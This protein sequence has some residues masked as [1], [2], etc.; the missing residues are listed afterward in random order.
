MSFSFRKRRGNL[1]L[2]STIEITL[3]VSPGVRHRSED[4]ADVKEH[5]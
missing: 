3:P 5:P 1:S 4:T 2:A